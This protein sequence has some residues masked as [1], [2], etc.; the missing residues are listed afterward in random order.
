VAACCLR[1]GESVHSYLG[2]TC[3]NPWKKFLEAN[4]C[5]ASQEILRLFWSLNSHC[6]QEYDTGPHIDKIDKDMGLYVFSNDCV[7][8]MFHDIVLLV[9]K[10]IPEATCS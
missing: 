7:Y 4:S 5:S 9:P 8:K 2:S 6:S 1:L 10:L 3:K